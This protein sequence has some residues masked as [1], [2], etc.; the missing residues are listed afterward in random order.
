MTKI[1]DAL[2]KYKWWFCGVAIAGSSCLYLAQNSSFRQKEQEKS[3]IVTMDK[4]RLQKTPE[5]TQEIPQSEKDKL[6]GYS[7]VEAFKYG[8]INSISEYIEK[9]P[10]TQ[11]TIQ[12]SGDFNS[13][14]TYGYYQK[15]K[16][17]KKV[18]INHIEPDTLS[19]PNAAPMMKRAIVSFAK[20]HND[21][22]KVKAIE[23]HEFGHQTQDPDP[24]VADSINIPGLEKRSI[25]DYNMSPEQFAIIVKESEVCARAW[26]LFTLREHYKDVDGKPSIFTGENSFYGKAI[27]SRLVDPFSEDPKQN[28]MENLFIMKSL[29]EQFKVK[30][31]ANY[32][33]YVIKMLENKKP[34]DKSKPNEFALARERLHTLIV[35][36][37]L[38]NLDYISNGTIPEPELSEREKQAVEKRTRYEENLRNQQVKSQNQD[39]KT[40][41]QQMVEVLRNNRSM[42]Y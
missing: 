12:F 11:D 17:T 32:E 34:E 37:K 5:K 39:K 20:Y 21:P 28:G 36:G 31:A 29:Y 8:V 38:V 26:G 4:P 1:K 42:G 15:I 30:D 14:V 9:A 16:G 41:P 7:M 3:Q 24:K 13:V 18:V 22:V 19:I 25:F 40:E 23:G 35:D 2:D 10:V 6:I 33:D 27:R